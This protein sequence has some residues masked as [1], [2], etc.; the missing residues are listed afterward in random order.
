ME[1][2]HW[3]EHGYRLWEP[4]VGVGD[5][6]GPRGG[7]PVVTP[8]SGH[9]GHDGHDRHDGLDRHD[10]H[11]R[12]GGNGSQRPQRTGHELAGGRDGQVSPGQGDLP[13]LDQHPPTR[14]LVL[15]G[16]GATG[17]AW[18][19]GVI[20]GLHDHGID[21][22]E[23]DTV[24]GT[25]A[26]SVVG[27]HLR[28][29]TPEVAIE[30][31]TRGE[32]LRNLGHIGGSEAVTLLRGALHP[33]RAAG[34][35]LV[36]AIATRSR[37]GPEEEFIDIVAGDIA[38][39]DWPERPLLITAVDVE[40]GTSVVFDRASGVPLKRA[41]AASCSVPGIF[42]P[43]TINGRRYM[44]GG[45]RSAANVDLSRGHD[46]ILVL[47]PIPTSFHRSTSPA[48]QARRLWNR[49]RTLTIIPDAATQRAIGLK[50]LD[51][52]RTRPALEAGRA[53]AERIAARVA[54]LWQT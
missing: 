35:A 5:G 21:L 42:P 16:G 41:M 51:M 33:N 37:T 40:D 8:H 31:I 18:M 54:R 47:A 24:I 2:Q 25:S 48:A 44:D 3:S 26:G 12:S 14:A 27:A 7:G 13:G 17:I 49:S 32:P 39:A 6:D 45:T 10:G 38:D 19:E 29:D 9:D 53:Q 1:P 34:R 20:A 50:F 23:A 28:L 52:R 22:R 36:G 11:G 30:R 43:V 46:R 4:Q 15:G